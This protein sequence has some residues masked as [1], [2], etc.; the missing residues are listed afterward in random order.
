MKD[1]WDVFFED[2]GENTYKLYSLTEEEYKTILAIRS[3]EAQIVLIPKNRN[4][5]N[6]RVGD[7]DQDDCEVLAID[8][9]GY[10]IS[11]KREPEEIEEA[12]ANGAKRVY[13]Q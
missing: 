5:P 1:R 10:Q 8:E 7:I 2:E 11:S 13:I 12:L 3:G 9:Y 4:T 6:I